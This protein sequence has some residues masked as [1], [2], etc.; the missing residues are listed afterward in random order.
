MADTSGAGA[1]VVAFVAGLELVWHPRGASNRP[2]ASKDARLPPAC[3]L[4]QHPQLTQNKVLGN[5]RGE[6]E[7]GGG[8]GALA[9]A[10]L[11]YL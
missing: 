11:I 5:Q 10:N 6:A 2:L 7:A 1:T 9:I 8:N 3:A 4:I